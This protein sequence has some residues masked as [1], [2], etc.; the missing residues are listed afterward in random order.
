M[1]HLYIRQNIKREIA[2]RS[3]K[4]YEVYTFNDTIIMSE[5]N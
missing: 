5:C 2:E 4:I 3:K 1:C